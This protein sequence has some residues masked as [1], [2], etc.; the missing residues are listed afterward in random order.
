M[1][2]AKKHKAYVQG[3]H[4]ESS[5]P[6]EPLFFPPTVVYS[7]CFFYDLSPINIGDKV[8]L[9]RDAHLRVGGINND[10]LWKALISTRRK[11]ERKKKANY[12]ARLETNSLAEL[13]KYI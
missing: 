5:G 3:R 13:K 4:V 11:A 8:D 7:N 2:R 10:E 6:I 1:V 12:C 9:G